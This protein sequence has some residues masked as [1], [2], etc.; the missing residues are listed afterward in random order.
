MGRIELPCLAA[1]Q[2][3][4]GTCPAR[5]VGRVWTL[6]AQRSSRFFTRWQRPNGWMHWR[7]T[8][9]WHRSSPAWFPCR[10]VICAESRHDARDRIRYLLADEV[11]LGKTHRSRADPARTE[12]ARHG[13]PHSG[14]GAQGLGAP[15][16][17]GNA[18][19]FWRRNFSSLSQ[20]SWLHSGSGIVKRKTSG[21]CTIR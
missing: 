7:I 18:S 13:A 6:C 12:T 11:G 3:R 19:A 17:G 9:C 5:R 10:T 2:G 20:Q 15:V 14:R 1:D 4:S 21:A 16:A 8:C